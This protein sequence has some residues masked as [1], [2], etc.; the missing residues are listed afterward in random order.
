VAE[1]DA[2]VGRAVQ[3]VAG[4]DVHRRTGDLDVRDEDLIVPKYR[5]SA[6]IQGS[7]DLDARLRELGIDTV[8]VV[9]T[10][11]NV[12]CESSARDA[13]MLN[14]KVIMV[15]DANATT[16]DA[17]HRASLA[18][19]ARS[20]GEVVSTDDLIARVTRS[21]HTQKAS[22]AGMPHPA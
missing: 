4:A 21:V 18:A 1:R 6:F 16:S 15:S 20:F 22:V 12:C 17:E 14:Y 7:S 5:Y 19:I 13:M 11:T 10:L 9:G 8:I 2:L 3:P